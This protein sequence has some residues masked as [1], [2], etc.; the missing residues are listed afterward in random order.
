MR[1]DTSKGTLHE[2]ERLD[3]EEVAGDHRCSVGTEELTP[4]ELGANAGRR[5]SRVTEELGD[6]AG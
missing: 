6:R 3:G 1:Y 5:D 4:V 2:A